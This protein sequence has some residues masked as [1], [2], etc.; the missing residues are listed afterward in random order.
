M[1]RLLSV[2]CVLIGLAGQLQ[3]QDNTPSGAPMTG[4]V[5]V[6]TDELYRATLMGQRMVAD[7]DERARALQSENDEITK[8]LTAEERSLTDR[9][10]TLD[11]EVFRAQ[12]AEF[13]MRV[14]GIR[15]TRDA[16]IA[17]FEAE[18]SASPRQFLELVRNVLGE[19]MLE[20]GAVAVLDQR[21]VFLSL[22][23]VDITQDAIARI[24]DT[25][26]DGRSLPAQ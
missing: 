13:D 26:G 12:A 19:L 15:R 20:R 11:P 3:A 17:T 6:D 4:V 9:R 23:T 8:A 16:A 22:G 7:L 24:D 2:G 18:R 14:Q 1:L 10:P 25:F 5:V 21:L